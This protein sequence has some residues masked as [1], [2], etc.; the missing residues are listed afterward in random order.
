MNTIPLSR[1][2]MEALLRHLVLKQF[3]VK[4]ISVRVTG[5]VGDN[6][7]LT[8]VK[9]RTVAEEDTEISADLVVD[10]TGVSQGGYHWL[11]DLY[12]SGNVEA[13]SLAAL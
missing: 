11:Q 5:L 4:Q 2:N 8:G 9:V 3:N 12:G 7:I 10:C 6:K 13:K 1:E